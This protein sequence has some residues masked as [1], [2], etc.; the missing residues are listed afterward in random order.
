[1]R[2]EVWGLG[3]SVQGVGFSVQR[4]RLGGAQ[5]PDFR[6]RQRDNVK[7]RERRRKFGGEGTGFAT[8]DGVH[9]Q[10]LPREEEAWHLLEFRAQGLRLIRV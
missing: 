5:R 6:E 9:V 4:Q 3:L 1:M 8:W 7:E 2:F 10:H